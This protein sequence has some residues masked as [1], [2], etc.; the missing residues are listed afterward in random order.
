[1]LLHWKSLH[2][3]PTELLEG[4]VTTSGIFWHLNQQQPHHSFMSVQVG[5][6][7]SFGL[8]Q[9][10]QRGVPSRCLLCAS[11]YSLVLPCLSI[12]M[13]SQQHSEGYDDVPGT[14][15]KPIGPETFIECKEALA[16]PCL[17]GEKTQINYET[18]QAHAHLPSN[19]CD[20]MDLYSCCSKWTG[21]WR[22][23]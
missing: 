22:C 7:V 8:P 6:G 13:T 11:L 3:P 10:R 19:M 23:S 16:L 9:G 2:W 18:H 14:E 4:A 5:Q 12:P 15:P 1:M 20:I 17:G 21:Q